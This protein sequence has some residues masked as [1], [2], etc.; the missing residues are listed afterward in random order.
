MPWAAAVLSHQ[1][2]R[3][4]ARGSPRPAAGMLKLGL[5]I[6]S[7]LVLRIRSRT[8]LVDHAVD[9]GAGAAV[10]PGQDL[11]RDPHAEAAVD[12]SLGLVVQRR[13]RVGEDRPI[14]VIA[15]IGF[16]RQSD[17]FRGA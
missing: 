5:S 11:R 9:A 3:A 13:H 14:G 12:L 2:A 8:H 16:Q 7:S 17:G 10:L 1:P 15:V 6:N 4:S